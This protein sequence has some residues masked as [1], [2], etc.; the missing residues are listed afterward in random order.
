MLKAVSFLFVVAVIAAGAGPAVAND[1]KTYRYP[2]EG[3]AVEFPGAPRTID[4][5]APA[6]QFVRG[7]QYL[8]TDDAK[9]EYLGQALHYQKFI[10][11]NNTTDKILRVVIDGAKDAAKCSIR[12]EKNYSFPGAFAR[13]VVIEKC[14]GG[15]AGKSR[16]LLLGDW[17]Y[18]VLAMGRPGIE[19]SAD[20]DRFIGSFSVIGK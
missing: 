20:A 4:M 17:L 14:E 18:F 6:A 5:N 13:E 2:N 16:V 10:R 3:F 11:Q 12:S 9:N 8:A 15:V 7:I 19:T 1:W